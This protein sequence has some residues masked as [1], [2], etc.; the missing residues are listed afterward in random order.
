MACGTHNIQVVVQCLTF[1]LAALLLAS[2]SPDTW[3]QP[4]VTA[5]L[6]WCICT[7]YTEIMNLACDRMLQLRDGL[8]ALSVQT[9]VALAQAPVQ[10]ALVLPHKQLA[11][12]V[13]W[14]LVLAILLMCVWRHDS[15][16]HVNPCVA[17]GSIVLLGRRDVLAVTPVLGC[18]P[19][20]W[21]M[22]KA[23]SLSACARGLVAPVWLACCVAT[24]AWMQCAMFAFV[25]HYC[26]P[27]LLVLGIVARQTPHWLPLLSLG[28]GAL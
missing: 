24:P 21:Q 16:V 12:G 7:A 19:L 1:I 20:A 25:G 9:F 22:P 6:T 3:P 15:Y 18:A 23:W 8:D 4:Y 27:G 5:L 14:A 26:H 10:S 13:L 17:T 2:W 11:R 28:I